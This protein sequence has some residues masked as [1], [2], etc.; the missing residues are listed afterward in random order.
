ML[1]KEEFMEQAWAKYDAWQ[2][3]QVDQGSGYSYEKSF[4]EMMISMGKDLLQKSV[5]KVPVNRKKKEK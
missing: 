2:K 5:G 3:S 4:D 1:S